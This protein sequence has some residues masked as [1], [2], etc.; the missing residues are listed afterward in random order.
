MEILDYLE[1]GKAKKGNWSALA[2][3]L[4]KAV[5]EVTDWRRGKHMPDVTSCTKLA[6]LLD[7]EPMEVISAAQIQLARRPE[8]RDFWRGFMSRHRQQSTVALCLVSLFSYVP[9][10]TAQAGE[11]ALERVN[12]VTITAHYAK[13]M[14][15]IVSSLRTSIWCRLW[16][17]I[18][19]ESPL[20]QPA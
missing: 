10:G 4:D 19:L 6:L 3:S 11:I 18:S 9:D 14:R 13:W 20:S 1:Q 12:P 5:T 15:H 2:R 17:A 8:N 7:I 16:S